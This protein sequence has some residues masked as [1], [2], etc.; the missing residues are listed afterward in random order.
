MS[1]L[2]LFIG[3]ISLVTLITILG[4]MVAE[5]RGLCRQILNRPMTYLLD[6]KPEKKAQ[7]AVNRRR[8]SE[9]MKAFWAKVKKE[10]GN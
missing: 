5:V 9:R 4:L 2:W 3:F 10:Q 6:H 1:E 7:T 8:A